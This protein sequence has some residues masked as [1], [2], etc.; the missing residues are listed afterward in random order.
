MNE[1]VVNT[2]ISE[3]E[4]K[5]LDIIGLKT[6]TSPNIKIGDIENKILDHVKYIATEE[7]IKLIAENFKKRLKQSDFVSK[8]DYDN[9]LRS[10]NENITLDKTKYLET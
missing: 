8:I 10:L 1:I 4:N 2:K 7:F 9:K 3:A 6:I 5:I